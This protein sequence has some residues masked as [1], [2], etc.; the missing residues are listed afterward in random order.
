MPV[1]IILRLNPIEIPKKYKMNTECSLSA[2]CVLI[3]KKHL[4][5]MRFGIW[6][7]G[8]I[9]CGFDPKQE[10]YLGTC[11]SSSFKT[12]GD[13]SSFITGAGDT[14]CGSQRGEFQVLVRGSFAAFSLKKFSE[15]AV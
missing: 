8:Q 12:L 5:L 13:F 7:R 10:K 11:T 1:A 6:I 4:R 15:M 2:V 3:L 14:R 9:E